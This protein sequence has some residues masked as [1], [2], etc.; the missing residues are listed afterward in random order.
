MILAPA[1]PAPKDGAMTRFIVRVRD[2]NGREYAPPFF[3]ARYRTDPGPGQ[4]S[5][6][7]FARIVP[8]V[9]TDLPIADDRVNLTVGTDAPG[10][11][12]ETFTVAKVGGR[13]LADMRAVTVGTQG[14][15]VT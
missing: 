8:G 5:V 9:P 3:V 12:G 10:F 15:T 1:R 13:W 6:P 2:V 7:A 11:S 14:G 4:D